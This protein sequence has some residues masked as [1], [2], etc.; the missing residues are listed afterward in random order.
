VTARPFNTYG[1]RQSARAVIPSIIIQIASGKKEIKLGDVSPT[2]DFNYVEDTCAGFLKLATCNKAIGETVN[3]G[4]GTEISI[5]DTLDMIKRIMK[6]DVK[7][8]TDRKRIRPK[9]SEVFRLFC[10]NTKIRKLTGFKPEFTLEEG[11]EKTIQWF[12]RPENLSR[13]KADI[14]QCIRA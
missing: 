13:Y 5:A 7:I 2:R 12:T 8:V 4:S 9:N 6:S 11:L 14:Y 1:P 10:D 3:I